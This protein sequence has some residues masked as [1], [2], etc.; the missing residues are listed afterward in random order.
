[1]GLCGF[2]ERELPA[3]GVEPTLLTERDFESRASANSATPAKE[4][5]NL[6]KYDR[7]AIRNIRFLREVGRIFRSTRAKSLNHQFAICCQGE[8]W[9]VV[10]IHVVF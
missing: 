4:S 9:K 7:R 8:Q 6:P 5:F 10:S 2:I 1:M 3:V